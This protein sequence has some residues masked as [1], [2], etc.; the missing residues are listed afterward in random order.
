MTSKRTGRLPRPACVGDAAFA[1][2][3]GVR[4]IFKS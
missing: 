3:P 1:G 2:D 4:E